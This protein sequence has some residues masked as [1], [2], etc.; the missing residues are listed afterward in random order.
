MREWHFEDRLHDRRLTLGPKDAERAIV[1][2]HPIIGFRSEELATQLRGALAAL[3]PRAS[4][5]MKK[6]RAR[7]GYH[8][9]TLPSVPA[10]EKA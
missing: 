8:V 9:V 10:E 3:A 5:T 1:D 6:P 4:D 7:R 2:L